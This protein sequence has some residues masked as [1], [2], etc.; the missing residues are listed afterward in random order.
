MCLPQNEA[1]GLCSSLGEATLARPHAE[2]P[3]QSEGLEASVDA[4]DVDPH[5]PPPFEGRWRSPPQ[6]EG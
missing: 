3:E 6:G 1:A 5:P 4:A 2:V